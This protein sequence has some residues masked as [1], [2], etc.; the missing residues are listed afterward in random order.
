[1]PSTPASAG[2]SYNVAGNAKIS[3][4]AVCMAEDSK[5]TDPSIIDPPKIF[6]RNPA[7]AISEIGAISDH[8]DTSTEYPDVV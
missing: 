2:T 6:A 4:N 8:G 1:M 7:S 5:G 3:E